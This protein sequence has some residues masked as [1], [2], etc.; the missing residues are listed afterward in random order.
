MFVMRL[1]V[2]QDTRVHHSRTID[3]WAHMPHDAGNADLC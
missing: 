2:I 3:P 1:S